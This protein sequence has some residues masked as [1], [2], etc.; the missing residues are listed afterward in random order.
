MSIKIEVVNKSNLTV[1][2]LF[3]L[4][5]KLDSAYIPS[6]SSL[7]DIEEYSNKLYT[8]A[9]LLILKNNGLE[10]G[11]CA[12]YANNYENKIA[13]ISSIGIL[14][15]YQGYGFGSKLVNAAFE[16]VSQKGFLY[17]DLEVYKENI[18]AYKFYLKNGFELQIKNGKSLILRKSIAKL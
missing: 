4:L 1:D 12:L 16:L 6:I 8:F 13:Y 10:I 7:V 15:E 5:S 18:K 17:V 3:K 9:D 14:P 2:C 11:I